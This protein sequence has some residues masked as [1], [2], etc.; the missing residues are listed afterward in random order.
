[1][2]NRINQDIGFEILGKIIIRIVR[3]ILLGL[4]RRKNQIDRKII[5]RKGEN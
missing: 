4:R 2:E 3:L 5:L 1:M